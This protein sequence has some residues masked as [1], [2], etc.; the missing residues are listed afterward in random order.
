[1]LYVS[2]STP[3]VVFAAT[4][5]GIRVLEVD[6]SRTN[7][8]GPFQNPTESLGTDPI[9]IPTSSERIDLL[10]SQDEIVFQNW[11]GDK[12]YKYAEI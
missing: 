11:T 2:D 8:S 4:K 9:H 10:Y 7:Y 1:M 5:R 6:G 3:L 12:L